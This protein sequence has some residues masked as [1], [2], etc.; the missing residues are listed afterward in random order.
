MRLLG[1]RKEKEEEK[2]QR[3]RKKDQERVCRKKVISKLLWEH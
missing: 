1:P 3:L 2:K